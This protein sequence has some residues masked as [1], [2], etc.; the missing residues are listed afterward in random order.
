M[1]REEM[2]LKFDA[3]NSKAI[4]AMG[5]ENEEVIKLIKGAET[6]LA[7]PDKYLYLF[8]EEYFYRCEKEIDKII[9]ESI[10]KESDE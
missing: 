5:M 7:F 8:D 2:K 6:I 4:T 1:T 10:E 9:I 3:I